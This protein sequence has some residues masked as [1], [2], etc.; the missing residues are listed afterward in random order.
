M[1]GP[2][3]TPNS[4]TLNINCGYCGGRGEYAEKDMLCEVYP[5]CLY[6]ST[7]INRRDHIKISFYCKYCTK[8]RIANSSFVP[9][10]V[11]DRLRVN[12]NNIF[13]FCCNTKCSEIFYIKNTEPEFNDLC[14]FFFC[15]FPKRRYY[16]C[17]CS[18]DNYVYMES[19]PSTVLNMLEDI[20][21]D[22]ALEKY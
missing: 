12:M 16:I 5:S 18:K 17:S 9:E 19:V 20:D 8:L 22:N 14:D 15:I 7:F 4:Y 21:R 6:V 3:T 13:L 2:Y 10:I 11:M 1:K